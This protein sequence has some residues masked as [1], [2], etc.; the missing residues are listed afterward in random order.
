EATYA[1]DRNKLAPVAIEHVNLPFRFK[2][3][4]T[5]SLLGWDGS[6]D[7]SE[8]RK[9]VEDITSIVGHPV[10]EA[11]RKADEDNRRRIDREVRN[12][13]RKYGAVAAAVA[14]LLILF[15]FVFWWP[16]PQ[17]A[18]LTEAE[19]QKEPGKEAPIVEPK[20]LVPA[21]PE[22]KPEAPKETVT[23]IPDR[24]A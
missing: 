13:W 23:H 12:P 15:S 16:K 5:P 11:R 7:A 9:L 10:G 24:P 14:V 1:L 8:F 21:A 22:R 20:V 3:V 2:G 18:P 19:G 6:K 4:H 17:E